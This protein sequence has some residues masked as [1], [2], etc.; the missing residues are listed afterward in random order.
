MPASALYV[1]SVIVGFSITCCDIGINGIRAMTVL[2]KVGLIGDRTYISDKGA[3][4]LLVLLRH[5]LVSLLH[6]L[7]TLLSG[8]LEASSDIL[9]VRTLV[10]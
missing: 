7:C 8:N 4:S 2:R 1:S 6:S 5:N 3:N 9:F 10:K